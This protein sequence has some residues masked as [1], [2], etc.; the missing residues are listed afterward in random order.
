LPEH[1]PREIVR[2]EPPA[3]CP[4]CGG[5]R[6]SIIGED[7]RE[8]LEVVPAQ[9]KVIIHGAAQDQLPRLRDHRPG[10][11]RPGPDRSGPAGSGLLAHVAT[12]KFCDHLPRYRQA[13]IYARSGLEIGRSLL[14][15]WMGHTAI[16]L[17]PLAEAI[18][19]HV[20]AGTVLHADDTPAP[21]PPLRHV[22]RQAGGDDAG[23]TGHIADCNLRDRRVNRQ[24]WPAD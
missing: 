20:R 5:T 4:G 23:E 19:E 1:L 15:E 17:Q 12:A 3:C 11:K 10:A 6:L 24:S 2:H 9:F 22:V 7:S 18:G 13:E 8:V 21:V 16:L 14:A